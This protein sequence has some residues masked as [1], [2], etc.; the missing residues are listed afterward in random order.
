MRKQ[1]LIHLHALLT[2]I[3]DDL[4]ERTNESAIA[5]EAYEHNAVQPTAIFARKGA[6]LDAIWQLLDGFDETLGG[7]EDSPSAMRG[8]EPGSTRLEAADRY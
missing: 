1:E 5:F 3:R 4:E 8:D 7:A 6:H 2:E